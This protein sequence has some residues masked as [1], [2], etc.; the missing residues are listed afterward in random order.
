MRERHFDPRPVVAV[1]AE[2]PPFIEYEPSRLHCGSS[3]RVA[4]AERFLSPPSVAPVALLRVRARALP[5][6]VEPIGSDN[7][8]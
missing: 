6:R 5:L 3:D 7:Y 4:P 1:V 2:A 8:L